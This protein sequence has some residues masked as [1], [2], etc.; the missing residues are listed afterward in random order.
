MKHKTEKTQHYNE[1]AVDKCHLSQ[2]LRNTGVAQHR[3]PRAGVHLHSLL[4][5]H[6]APTL[7]NLLP[8]IQTQPPK[9]TMAMMLIMLHYMYTSPL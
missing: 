7:S 1:P 6:H 9:R 5:I 8:I 2:A 3:S 4:Y